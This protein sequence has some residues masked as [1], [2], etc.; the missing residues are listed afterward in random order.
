MRVPYGLRDG[1][2]RFSVR[3]DVHDVYFSPLLM[4]QFHL[5]SIEMTKCYHFTQISQ[6]KLVDNI[7][8]KYIGD[9]KDGWARVF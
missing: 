6:K 1:F 7:Q 8:M 5:T 9:R 4:S 2:N 3:T